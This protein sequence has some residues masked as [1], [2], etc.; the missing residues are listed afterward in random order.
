MTKQE[1]E[2]MY[3]INVLYYFILFM[4]YSTEKRITTV[5]WSQALTDGHAQSSLS[6]YYIVYENLKTSH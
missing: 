5:I 2:G 1:F 3:F 6:N 4:F